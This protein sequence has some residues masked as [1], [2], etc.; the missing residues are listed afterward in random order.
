MSC[1]IVLRWAHVID[2]SLLERDRWL[3]RAADIQNCAEAQCHLY[4]ECA[5]R[6]VTAT[7]HHD[8]AQRNLAAAAAQCHPL[9]FFF[10]A[11]ALDHKDATEDDKKRAISY[12]QPASDAGL[13]HG[14]T[15]S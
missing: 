11:A 3:R 15:R 8:Q 10:Q 2:E 1:A 6:G 14:N 7:E 13:Q 4:W 5:A 12:I 9:A